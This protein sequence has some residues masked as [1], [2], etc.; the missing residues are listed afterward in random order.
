[1]SKIGFIGLGKL[2]LPMALAAESRGHHVAGWDASRAVRTNIE[3]RVMPYE[4][5]GAKA[6]LADSRL[7]LMDPDELAQW[8][9]LI[10]VVIQTPHDPRFEGTVPLATHERADF[11]YIHLRSAIID[12][13]V[14]AALAERKVTVAIVSTVLPGTLE[15]EILPHAGQYLDVVYNPSLI[16][17]GTAVEDF[18]DPEM[19][20]VGTTGSAEAEADL[21]D[22]YGTIHDAPVHVTSIASAEL[23]KVA[24][25]VFIGAK[26]G[27]INTMAQV[28]E[29]TGADVDDITKGLALAN[30]RII[31]TRYLRAGMGDGGGCH[32]RDQIALSWLAHRIGLRHDS[33]TAMIREREAHADWLAKLCV[34]EANRSMENLPIIVLGKAYKAD[35]GITTGSPAVLL[36]HYLDERY[37]YVKAWD[38]FVDE[39]PEPDQRAVYVV[40][41]A[42]GIFHDIVIPDGSI[43]VDPWGLYDFGPDIRHVYP[44]RVPVGA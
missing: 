16:A 13:S 6:L 35:S 1:M 23:L 19:V 43:V 40:G 37:H 28:C 44:G 17:M 31:S 25:N 32:P 24:Y 2:G 8:A 7:H 29:S 39:E 20:I 38:P 26:L 10:F 22:F 5:P 18:L 30:R 3:E 4:E 11:D 9:D 41:T 21:L 14:S 42:H 36:K 33:F 27:F 12:L 34:G 15:R